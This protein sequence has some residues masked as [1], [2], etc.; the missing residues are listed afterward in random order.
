MLEKLK[1][2]NAEIITHKGISCCC[3]VFGSLMIG[4]NEGKI[5]ITDFNGVQWIGFFILCI[6]YMIYF[7][8]KRAWDDWRK[9]ADLDNPDDFKKI[10][11]GFETEYGVMAY[12]SL[13]IHGALIV[14]TL[15]VIIN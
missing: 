10:E 4:S 1:D 15:L 5:S 8:K 11:R 13:F 2:L 9:S 6:P 7:E 3:L 14:G 12:M